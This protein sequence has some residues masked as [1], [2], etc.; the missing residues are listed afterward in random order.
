[1]NKMLT[2][3]KCTENP[4]HESSQKTKFLQYHTHTHTQNIC[5]WFSSH[6]NDSFST[7]GSYYTRLHCRSSISCSSSW[8]FGA[9]YLSGPVNK[10][11]INQLCKESILFRLK[12]DS[13]WGQ[14]VL[15]GHHFPATNLVSLWQRATP[16][17]AAGQLY[18]GARIWFNKF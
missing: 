17:T 12:Y 3:Q 9:A 4:K 16:S 2:N 15:T 7:L 14:R 5:A 11:I 6:V 8:Q 10:M 1:M 13:R 18:P